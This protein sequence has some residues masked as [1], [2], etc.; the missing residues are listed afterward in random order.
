[1]RLP[2]PPLLLITDRLS[3]CKDLGDVLAAAFSAGCCWVMV[4]EKDLGA[5]ELSDLAR[6]VMAMGGPASAMIA[7]NGDARAA[8]AAG[9][10]DVHL[11]QD[12]FD[13]GRGIAEVRRLAGAN[14]VIGVSTHSMAEAVQAQESGADYVTLSPIFSTESKP[15]Y[16]PALGLDQLGCVAGALAIP[17]IALG[18]V[19]AENARACMK[20]GALGIAV[21][22][23]VMRAE[24]PGEAVAR[25]VRTLA[26]VS[27]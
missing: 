18:G 21:M 4:R 15:G 6:S 13:G 17:V 2:R 27:A 5:S 10:K 7:V 22:G 9:A 24:D 8:A 12:A 14:A 11:P 16:G 23:S 19:T 3:T 25:L 26:K 1:M 20:A